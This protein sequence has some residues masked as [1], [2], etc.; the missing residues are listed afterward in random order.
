M[1]L[2]F[3]GVSAPTAKAPV[4]GAFPL[5]ITPRDTW[6]T[7]VPRLALHRRAHPEWAQM[8]ADAKAQ[9]RPD[10]AIWPTLDMV[11][12]GLGVAW[13]AIVEPSTVEVG[14]DPHDI[15]WSMASTW[16]GAQLPDPPEV[17]HLDPEFVNGVGDAAAA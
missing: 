11:G 5:T 9:H 10:Y 15:D 8:V 12:L 6:G 4:P 2:S 16:S 1:R 14:E 3:L 13:F 7:M 17:I